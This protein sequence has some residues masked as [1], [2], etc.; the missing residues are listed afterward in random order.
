MTEI[1]QFKL[2]SG[3]EIICDIVQWPD[4]ENDE[5]DMIVR[6]IFKIVSIDSTINGDKYYT[7]RPWLSF[8]DEED[9]L[10]TINVNHIMGEANPSEKL[11]THYFTAV[12]GGANEASEEARKDIQQKLEDYINNLRSNLEGRLLES[13]DS[14]FDTNIVKFPG[15][16]L[17]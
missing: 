12:K 2:S 17:H 16:V 11:L 14:D 13:G 15:R 9:M 4:F 10:Q 1:K 5:G 3:E 6:N 7:F 8:Q